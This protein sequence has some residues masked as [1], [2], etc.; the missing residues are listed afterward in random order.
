M[1]GSAAVALLGCVVVSPAWSQVGIPSGVTP[2]QIQRQ[3]QEMREP[4]PSP[5]QTLP[6]P[7]E[8]PIPPEASQLRFTLRKVEV[9][10]ASVY[11]ER[12]I[13]DAFAP[14]IGQEISAADVFRIANQLTAR[15]RRD[16][17]I[18][19]EVLVPAQSITDGTVRLL[20]VEGYI[21]QVIYR[22][23]V[24]A[25]NA[26][27]ASFAKKLTESRPLTAATLERYLLL[28]N[29]L[30][31]TQARGTLVPSAQT[32][33]AADLVVDFSRSHEAAALGVNN[34]Q[35]RSLGPYQG[36][37]EL[38]W[39]G[40]GTAWNHIA[41][42]GGTSFNSQLN[43]VG[44]GYGQPI[45]HEG[46]HW[47]AEVTGVQSHPA[48]AANLTTSDLHTKSVAG[49]LDLTHPLWRS[50]EGDLYLHLA[51]TSFDGRSQF[52]SSNLSDDHIRALRLGMTLDVTDSWR[53]V[54]TLQGEFSQG[55]NALG[56]S[57]TG[58]PEEPLS[59][60]GG[61]A[62]FSKV[63]L[64][65]ARLQSLGGPWSV[66]LAVE[67][68][69]AFD[70]LLEPELFAFGGDQFGRGYD[71]AEI[72]GDSGA[73]GKAE[74][75]LT[76]HWPPQWTSTLYGFYDYGAVRQRNPINQA[77]GDHADSTGLGLRVSGP[78]NRWQGFLEVAKPLDHVVAAE[79]NRN[80]RVFF[81]LQLNL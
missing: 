26:L 41:L 10:G 67:G 77:T 47:N 18:L 4:Q 17:Y 60:A 55:L 16:G 45:G 23:N 39:F 75:R 31:D 35:S 3:L 2:G 25:D 5:G 62:D 70:T 53:G 58:T 61:K 21:A 6:P 19:S 59:R 24:P 64:Y 46:T 42:N 36:T 13:D 14:H 51:L 50:R 63:S 8:Q 37:A 27:L 74:L 7:P 20:V 28:M 81:G 49:V 66:L 34:R 9:S 44:I 79:G 65:A 48:P 52:T 33:G 56:A 80:A 22:G 68:Q 15:Y 72:V 30:G 57:T 11:G 12:V 76:G 71:F 1:K 32:P 54:N 38:D 69:Y 40:V 29:D 73:A 78:R 43:F